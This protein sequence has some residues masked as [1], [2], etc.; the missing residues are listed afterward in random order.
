MKEGALWQGCKTE[1]ASFLRNPVAFG[2]HVVN[3]G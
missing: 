3:P 1:R 2:N